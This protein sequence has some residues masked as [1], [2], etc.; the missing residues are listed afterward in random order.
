MRQCRSKN[1]T[2]A[3]DGSWTGGREHNPA[4]AGVQP[5]LAGAVNP[6]QDIAVDIEH[7][8]YDFCTTPFGECLVV[9]TRRGICQLEFEARDRCSVVEALQSAAARVTASHRLGKLILKVLADPAGELPRL[10]LRGTAFQLQVW[11]ALLAI[12]PGQTESY[13][14]V[15]ERIGRPTAV[16]AVANAVAHN[17]VSFLVPCHR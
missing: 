13:R 14:Q 4:Q 11:Q 5:Q 6:A 9:A 12:R 7:L 16:R 3:W 10:D 15:A 1:C 2:L 8:E 17:P